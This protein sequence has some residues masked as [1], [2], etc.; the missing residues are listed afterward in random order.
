V[1]FHRVVLVVA[2]MIGVAIVARSILGDTDH[3]PVRT[4]RAGSARTE[5]AWALRRDVEVLPARPERP[6]LVQQPVADVRD[7]ATGSPSAD[8]AGEPS[9]SDP[10]E[11]T[12]RLEAT[13][14]S[15]P[16]DRASSEKLEAA[17]GAALAARST[18][19]VV[20]AA[21]CAASLCKVTLVHETVD[22]Q[23]DLAS[24]VASIPAVRDG[25]FYAY[26]DSERP[27]TVLYIV[28]P[29]HAFRDLLV[30]Q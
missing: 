11:I 16:P 15:E 21:R 30:R 18:G 13:Y 19:T 26:E 25:A 22:A 8:P 14:A 24:H 6:R 5:P 20:S 12:Q 29:G 23:R 3:E 9:V 7:A 2:G 27:R 4:S 28:R 10:A 1:R 17:L